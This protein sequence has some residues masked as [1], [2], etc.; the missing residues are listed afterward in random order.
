MH[1]SDHHGTTTGSTIND[2]LLVSSSWAHV[3]FDTGAS[4]SFISMLFASMLGLEYEPLESTLSMGVP[5]GRD[6]EFSF[7]CGS[8]RIDIEGRQLLANLVIMPMDQFDVILGMDWLSKYQGV[9]DCA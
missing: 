8:V 9:I 4:H 7:W 2:M 3:L 1:T 6:C 5:L